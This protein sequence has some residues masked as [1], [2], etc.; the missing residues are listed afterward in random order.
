[1]MQVVQKKNFQ[2]ADVEH[3]LIMGDSGFAK[4]EQHL[5]PEIA[6]RELRKIKKQFINDQKQT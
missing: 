6:I 3:L 1:M 5:S 4:D 2:N